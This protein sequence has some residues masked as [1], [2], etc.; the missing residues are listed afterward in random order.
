MT[1]LSRRTFLTIAGTIPLWARTARAASVPVGIE[2][3]TVRDAL[4]KD[5]M[6]TVRAV[7]KLGYQVV[8]F[9]SPYYSWTPAAGGDIASCSTI[10]ASVPV[11]AQRPPGV[12]RRRAP[13]GDRAEPG[14]RQQVHR[15]GQPR[16]G[17]H[18]RQLEGRRRSAE[19]R[20]REAEAA[21]HV[22]R[23]PQPRRRVAAGGRK[24][25][26]DILAVEH[27]TRTSRCSSTSAR[28]SR[29]APTQ[30]P[31][32]TRT[33]A[34]SRAC[35]ARTG[36]RAAEDYAVLFGEGDAPWAKIFEAAE[37]D[38]RHRVLPDRAGSRPRRR[39]VAARRAVPGELEEDAG[40]EAM[41]PRDDRA[42]ECGPCSC[43][44]AFRGG[45]DVVLRALASGEVVAVRRVDVHPP[46]LAI[47]APAPDFSLPGIDGKTTRS[48]ASRSSKVLVV[49]FTAVH[50]PTAEVYEAR[51]KSL[52]TDYTP[53]GVAFVVIQPNNA[54]ALR[55]DE[56]GYTDL[57]DS[58]EE[59]KIR[60]EHRQFNFPFLYDGETQE[61]ATQVRADRH[62]ARV[63]L[64]QRAAAPLPGPRRQQP[65]R[66]AGEGPRRAQRASMPCSPARPCPSRRR[67]PSAARSSGSRRKRCTTPRWRRS[68]PSP[69]R[70][71]RSRPTRHQGAC[72]RTPPARRCS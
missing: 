68:R 42:S 7:A 27:A 25:P 66:G 62:A 5:L 43:R 46:P 34:G 21:R 31:G 60:A 57:G 38:G 51:I 3:Y 48:P 56:M 29:P 15:H 20:R 71:R 45:R 70:S 17:L 63:R 22:R 35:T 53:K 40:A 69:S 54:K 24:R 55:L 18:R 33:R 72:G 26:M 28:A 44:A 4:A 16:R 47:G 19:R 64:R 52:V 11:D 39:A 50:C 30:S 49:I 6:G 41:M 65:A 67:R 59:M 14:H 10:S 36:R 58:L 9:Y 8:E 1:T 2:L 37:S 12:H 23:V 13:E 32:S 61:V